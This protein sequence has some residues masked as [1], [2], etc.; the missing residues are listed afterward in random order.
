MLVKGVY[1]KGFPSSD[2]EGVG[3]PPG[4]RN[5][6]TKSFEKQEEK[7][8]FWYVCP[9]ALICVPV[10]VILETTKTLHWAQ[11]LVESSLS[12]TSRQVLFGPAQDN[13]S[14]A[15]ADLAWCHVHAD[16][17]QRRMTGKVRVRKEQGRRRGRND[18]EVKAKDLEKNNQKMCN[19][20]R[21]IK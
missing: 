18:A 11:I 10:K 5:P 1:P 19:H 7:N 13:S 21:L 15:T 20:I 16:L 8:Y 2:G 17:N 6:D 4:Y 14:V 3:S 9:A 12:I